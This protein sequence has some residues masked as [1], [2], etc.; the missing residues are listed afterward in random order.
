MD[1]NVFLSDRAHS[2]VYSD[3]SQLRTLFDVLQSM[4]ILL[5]FVESYVVLL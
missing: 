2:Q 3:M 1:S 4:F 5:E